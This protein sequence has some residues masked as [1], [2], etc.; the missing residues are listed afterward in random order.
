[1]NR[2][3]NGE[4]ASITYQADTGKPEAFRLNPKARISSNPPDRLHDLLIVLYILMPFLVLL[5]A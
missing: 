3:S 1:M 5:F 4:S 2:R